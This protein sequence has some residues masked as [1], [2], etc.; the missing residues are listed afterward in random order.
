VTRWADDAIGPLRSVAET[1]AEMESALVTGNVRVGTA[2]ADEVIA[3]TTALLD[4]LD[5]DSNPDP[6]RD[7]ELISTLRAYRNAAFV[8]RKVAG[9]S[10]EPDPGTGTLCAA[11]IEQGHDHLR[12][13][14]NRASGDGQSTA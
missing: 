4:E 9:V 2:S 7:V 13:F 14:L 6:A 10:G 8:Y 12:A 11:M 1:V 3:V 5:R